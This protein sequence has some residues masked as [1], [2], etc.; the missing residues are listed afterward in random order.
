MPLV[1]LQRQGYDVLL[2]MTAFGRAENGDGRGATRSRSER[3]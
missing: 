1:A 2:A 3:C